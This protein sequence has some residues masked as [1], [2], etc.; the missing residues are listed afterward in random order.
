MASETQASVEHGHHPASFGVKE[1]YVTLN[2]LVVVAIIFFVARKSV[3]EA[4]KGRAAGFRKRL[5]ESRMELDRYKQEIQK[6]RAELQN[7]DAT[8]RTILAETEE[9]GRKLSERLVAESHATA[10]RI[11][12]DA[13]AAAEDEVRTAIDQ[14]RSNLVR[15]AV[16][17]AKDA[18][19][20]NDKSLQEKAHENLVN[21]FFKDTSVAV[22]EGGKKEEERLTNG[23]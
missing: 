9:E 14:L 23:K 21:Q 6:A 3:P 5:V 11:L 12:S 20:S 7:L 13:K 18:M 17:Q 22:K 16:R 1:V 8:K 2:L 10:T 15:E 19:N 4:L